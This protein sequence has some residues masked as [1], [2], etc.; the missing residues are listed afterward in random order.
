MLLLLA[1]LLTFYCPLPPSF[2]YLVLI[3]VVE[4]CL[5]S[6]FDDKDFFA[7]LR[8]D[9]LSLTIGSVFNVTVCVNRT[10]CYS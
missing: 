1:A 10:R 8:P 6:L 2:T 5:I 3:D 7:F 4:A 9:L